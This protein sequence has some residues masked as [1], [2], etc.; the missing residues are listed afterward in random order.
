MEP[1]EPAVKV[2]RFRAR[3]RRAL[4]SA[5]VDML[6]VGEEKVSPEHLFL[7]LADDDGCLACRILR[8]LG[9][10]PAR[11][12]EL[13]RQVMSGAGHDGAATAAARTRK[14]LDQACREA[15]AA[16]D[17]HAGSEH[18]LLALAADVGPAGQALGES[19]V[20]PDA[21]RR[22]L[23]HLLGGAPS[24][25]AAALDAVRRLV[26]TGLDEP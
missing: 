19:A 20:T 26:D 11:T 10:H 22:Q 18:L 1:Y 12:Q 4:A 14:V 25:R 23:A 9:F 5:E 3:V 15:Q 8:G 24:V 7:S 13:L 6:L 16:R 2:T 21:I 17:T